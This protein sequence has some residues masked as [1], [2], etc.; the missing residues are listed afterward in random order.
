ML[1]FFIS[2]K[3]EE[4]YY[5]VTTYL[6]RAAILTIESCI[7]QICFDIETFHTYKIV[8]INRY[9]YVKISTILLAIKNQLFL[10]S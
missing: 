4:P 9:L 6:F 10:S 5:N 8:I 1:A 3:F 7:V 2:L